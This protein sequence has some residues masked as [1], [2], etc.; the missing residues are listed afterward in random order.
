MAE[1]LGRRVNPGRAPHLDRERVSSAVHVQP[2]GRTVADKPAVSAPC[3]LPATNSRWA[4]RAVWVRRDQ[5][6]SCRTFLRI[7]KKIPPLGRTP[8]QLQRRDE[9]ALYLQNNP[10]SKR[11]HSRLLALAPLDCWRSAAAEPACRSHPLRDGTDIRTLAWA[12]I[13]TPDWLTSHPL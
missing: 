10:A 2:R 12:S 7:E 5:T 3:V 11:E 4:Q 13:L 8:D 1:R 6:A 9:P